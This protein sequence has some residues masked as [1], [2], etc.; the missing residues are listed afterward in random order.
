MLFASNLGS[1]GRARDV[2]CFIRIL[3]KGKVNVREHMNALEQYGSST[4]KLLIGSRIFQV[5]H[6]YACYGPQ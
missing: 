4:P 3:E 1:C 2:V 5:N 6:Q